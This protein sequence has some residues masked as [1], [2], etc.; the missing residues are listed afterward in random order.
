MT[1]N[2]RNY[3]DSRDF[4]P[5]SPTWARHKRTRP[6][7]PQTNGKSERFNR[8][9]LDEWAYARPYETNTSGSR[10][11]R[12]RHRYNVHR[13]HTALN[14]LTPMAVL[15]N[16][17]S[18][19]HTWRAQLGD[20]AAT[21]TGRLRTEAPGGPTVPRHAA[22][23]LIAFAAATSLL[24]PAH[25]RLGRVPLPPPWPDITDAIPTARMIVV[26][27]IVTD[28]ELADLHLGPNQGAR[29][30]ALRVTESCAVMRNPAT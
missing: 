26:G 9:M 4:R 7:R 24:G 15:V 1:D 12:L 29:D 18:G 13:P 25:A 6:H 21:A 27:E 5:P 17:V 28:F 11:A 8:T 3:V 19:N 16:N 30:Y 20:D 22:A 2:A 23:I 14:G 10:V